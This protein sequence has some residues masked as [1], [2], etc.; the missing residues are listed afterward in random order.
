MIND[1]C[2]VTVEMTV[3]QNITGLDVNLQIKQDSNI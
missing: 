1:V 2:E 3:F